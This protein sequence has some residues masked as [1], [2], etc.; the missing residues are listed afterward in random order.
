MYQTQQFY[1]QPVVAQPIT[2]QPVLYNQPMYQNQQVYQ[3]PVVAQPIA[4]QPVYYNQPMVMQPLEVTQ[5]SMPMQPQ[6]TMCAQ[7]PIAPVGRKNVA[8]TLRTPHTQLTINAQ[9][10]VR[11]PVDHCQHFGCCIV[12][13]CTGISWLPCWIVSC[14]TG[15]CPQPWNFENNFG[16]RI[17]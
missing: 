9:V 10:R 2:A 13:I 4:A 6:P 3:Q 11:P 1:Q 16:N 12:F 15:W 17:F 5:Q 7:Q 8:V 14:C